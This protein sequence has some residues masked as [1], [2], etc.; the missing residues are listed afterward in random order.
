M[1]DKAFWV[2]RM[3]QSRRQIDPKLS[4]RDALRWN[5]GAGPRE[6]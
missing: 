2:I 5:D 3:A 4:I 1:R 6:H